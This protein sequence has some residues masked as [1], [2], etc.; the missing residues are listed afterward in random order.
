MECIIN[1]EKDANIY[2]ENDPL[3]IETELKVEGITID[4]YCL[5]NNIEQIDILKIDVQGNELKV[6]EGAK[7]MLTNNRIKLIFLEISIASNYE[8]QSEIDQVIRLL[9]IHKYRIFNFFKMK[10]Q[11]GRLIECDALFYL[12]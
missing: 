5:K 1:P 8:G 2:W 6:L 9:K 11:E 4:Q 10:H 7:R 12:D 3:S